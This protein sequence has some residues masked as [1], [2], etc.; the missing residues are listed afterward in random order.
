VKWLVGSVSVLL[1][2]VLTSVYPAFRAVRLDPAQAM[3]TYE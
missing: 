2:V 3:R 1:L